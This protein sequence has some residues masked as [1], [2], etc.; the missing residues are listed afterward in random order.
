MNRSVSATAFQ[1]EQV[2]MLPLF[3]Q[4]HAG[5]PRRLKKCFPTGKEHLTLQQIAGNI[6]FRSAPGITHTREPWL[7]SV[8]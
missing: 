6:T 5:S 8:L 7:M 4:V 2:Q 1:S 3:S